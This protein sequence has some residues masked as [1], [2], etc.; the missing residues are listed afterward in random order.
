VDQA[1]ENVTAKAYTVKLSA[2]AS[3]SGYKVSSIAEIHFTVGY[4]Q[5]A[6]VGEFVENAKAALHRLLGGSAHPLASDFASG[7]FS[8]LLAAKALT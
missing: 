4:G 6:T 8:L 5:T 3:V 1:P 2:T 7:D